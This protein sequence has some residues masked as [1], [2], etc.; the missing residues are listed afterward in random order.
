MKVSQ[1]EFT[2]GN[3]KLY[4]GQISYF[5]FELTGICKP[6]TWT[7]RSKICLF[8]VYSIFSIIT[9]SIFIFYMLM[10][11]MKNYQTFESEMD[12]YFYFLTIMNAYYKMMSIFVQRQAVIESKNLFTNKF[13]LPRDRFE[14]KVLQRTS[15]ICR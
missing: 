6:I 2:N 7:T 14:L 1:S 15:N 13:C 5:I 10:Y 8:H 4:I 3:Y 12:T 9:S 11:I